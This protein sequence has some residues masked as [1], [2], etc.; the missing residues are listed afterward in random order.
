MDF[1]I[2]LSYVLE[3]FQVVKYCVIV[4]LQI[5]FDSLSDRKIQ[6]LVIRKSLAE[7]C[8]ALHRD[9]MLL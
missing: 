9:F 8:M 4:V 7:N 2:C 1:V 3:Y 6:T 5:M